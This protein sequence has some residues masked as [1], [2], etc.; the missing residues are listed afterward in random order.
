M[1]VNLFPG[2][3]RQK[4]LISYITFGLTILGF[5]I[6]LYFELG[7]FFHFMDE[8]DSSR[9]AA[10]VPHTQELEADFLLSIPQIKLVDI[11]II[12]NVD[13]GNQTKYLEALEDGVA[14]FAGTA[15]PG[16]KGN[17][18][19]FGHSSYYANKP[20]KYKEVFRNLNK[21]EEGDQ[22]QIKSN[23][24]TYQYTVSEKKIVNPKAVEV[25]EHPEDSY[26]LTL[27]TCWPLGSTAK[28]LI[29]IAQKVSPE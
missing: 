11:P 9:S 17:S 7:A 27:M 6:F 22:I 3:V 16:A 10:I 1:Y 2:L 13:G 26:R 25:L 24:K 19:I 12:L 8:M 23:L 20:G 4:N 28:R 5:L 15:L 21:L 14:H 29:V 18:F